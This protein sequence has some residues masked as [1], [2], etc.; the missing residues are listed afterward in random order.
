MSHH[1]LRYFDCSHLVEGPLRQT[2]MRFGMLATELDELLPECSEK[3]VAL[4]K[5]LEAKDSAVR[6]ALDVRE[7]SET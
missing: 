6:A 3:T 1:L 4:R 7:W 2:S 5:L